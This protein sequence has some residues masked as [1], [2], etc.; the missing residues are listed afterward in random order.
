MK[1]K[2]Q[3]TIYQF[4]LVEFGFDNFSNYYFSP[5]SQ[6]ELFEKLKQ[7]K[8]L[9][10]HKEFD[11]KAEV[12]EI[13]LLTVTQCSYALSELINPLGLNTVSIYCR[14]L[15]YSWLCGWDG[16]GVGE[17]I[18]RYKVIKKI[19]KDNSEE[20]D[21][22]FTINSCITLLY[23][24][25][26]TSQI[27][28]IVKYLYSNQYFD[29]YSSKFKNNNRMWIESFNVNAHLTIAYVEDF[30]FYRRVTK[31][32]FKTQ[33]GQKTIKR[34]E[35]FLKRVEGYITLIDTDLEKYDKLNIKSSTDG[36]KSFSFTEDLKGKFIESF[37]ITQILSEYEHRM[38]DH[39]LSVDSA[40]EILDFIKLQLKNLNDTDKAYK[41]K[42]I[43]FANNLVATKWFN[44]LQ[45]TD[46]Y[47]AIYEYLL[48]AG[49][50]DILDNRDPRR[51]TE[52][53]IYSDEKRYRQ[54]KLQS[55][56]KLEL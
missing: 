42:S 27:D 7:V 47:W 49:A 48:A 37:D 43:Q 11:S 20:D 14:T 31:D 2:K 50:Y 45:V 28:N 8:D 55:L 19:N 12:N 13:D 3:K 21:L 17:F 26:A 53:G 18:Q 41:E 5:F 35:D 46:Q 15:A 9:Y 38:Q 36:T 16:Y 54:K 40:H 32:F 6:K 51:Q 30:I 23:N 34:V 22:D 33:F 25:F 29:D 56:Y 44:E 1:L 39:T 24:N 10:F 52:F 4:N